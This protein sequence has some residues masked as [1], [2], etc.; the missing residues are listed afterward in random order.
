MSSHVCVKYI[1]LE[2]PNLLQFKFIHLMERSDPQR[3]E[4]L[5]TAAE[6]NF[7]QDGGSKV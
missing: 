6:E 7:P 5:A 3:G 1:S 2:G 4:R